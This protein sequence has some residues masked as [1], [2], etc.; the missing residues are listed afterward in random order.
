[1]K[2]RVLTS[3]AIIVV[4]LLLIIFSGYIVYPIA[5]AAI[6]V[7]ALFEILRVMKLHKEW[8][9]SLPAYLLTLLFPI[10]AYFVDGDRVINF[11]LVL[12][13]GLFAYMMW[14][15]AVSVFSK[16]KIAF[17]RM[18]EAFVAVTYVAVAFTSLSLLRYLDRE[19]GVFLVVLVFVISWICDVFAYF[20]GT[21]IGKHKLIP[22][23]SPKKTVEGSIGGIVCATLLA[24]LYGFIV[25]CATELK[26]NYLVLVISRLK[27]HE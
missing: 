6:A 22:E 17:T 4:G 7:I 24:A 13:A 26:P 27:K 9:V 15:M 21:L 5:L 3:L 25:S 11:L 8:A 12:A 16:G 1:M 14:L 20:T 23:V 10:V 19:F 18:S 2:N